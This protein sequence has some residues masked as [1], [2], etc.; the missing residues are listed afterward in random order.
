MP[1]CE[2]TS[3]NLILPNVPDTRL[4]HSTNCGGK[5]KK[6]ILNLKVNVSS[7][8]DMLARCLEAI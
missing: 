3:L 1:T 4:H 5:K 2:L 6:K 8:V 7:G